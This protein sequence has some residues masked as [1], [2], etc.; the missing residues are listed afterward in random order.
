M[1]LPSRGGPDLGSLW[2]LFG[3]MSV[4][5]V[6][7]RKTR[8]QAS[9]ETDGW[10]LIDVTSQSSDPIFQKFSPFF[11]HG[12]IPVPGMEGVMAESVEGIWQGLKVFD[13]DGVDQTK[14]HIRSMKN[15]KRPAGG[16]R[17]CVVGH[18]FGTHILGYVEARKRIYIPAYI[19]VL[20]HRLTA[21]VEF[22]RGLLQEHGK[23]ALVDFE[24]NED[25]E[26]TRKPL[27]HASILGTVILG[28]AL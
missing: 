21:E 10:L 4:R 8:E 26:D 24:T 1:T 20:E 14:F 25:V 12:D 6:A 19:W 13:E 15:L 17:G 3:P 2:I 27:S 22:L 23:I 11:P 28:Q 5:I 16:K 9:L 7:K 18:A